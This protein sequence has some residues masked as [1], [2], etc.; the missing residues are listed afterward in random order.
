MS[1][2][3]ST[4]SALQTSKTAILEILQELEEE[5]SEQSAIL[6]GPDDDDDYYEDEEEDAKAEDAKAEEAKA[7]EAKAEEAEADGAS[8]AEIPSSK[9]CRV[10]PKPR[11][12]VDPSTLDITDT[13]VRTC[14]RAH[15]F[16]LKIATGESMLVNAKMTSA[17]LMTGILMSAV[18]TPFAALYLD[19]DPTKRTYGNLRDTV[20]LSIET[21]IASRFEMAAL[22]LHKRLAEDVCYRYEK[23]TKGPLQKLFNGRVGRLVNL[24]ME[25][26]TAQLQTNRQ[27][28]KA[29]AMTFAEARVFSVIMPQVQTAGGA[30]SWFSSRLEVPRIEV[31]SKM[32]P[33]DILP[34]PGVSKVGGTEPSPFASPYGPSGTNRHIVMRNVYEEDYDDK[35]EVRLAVLDAVKYEMTMWALD[36][37]IVGLNM[38]T[39]STKQSKAYV[40]NVMRGPEASL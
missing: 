23:S 28:W 5:I 38:D 19:L 32:L 34:K 17:P 39:Q 27:S 40:V 15:R 10:A 8:C 12:A 22:P 24:A 31:V 18:T 3:V 14:L 26:I 30:Q 25:K 7:E 35:D 37:E 33:V 36:K 2:S 13:D 9:R 20:R 1:L 11:M 29:F 6:F 16:A 4:E 21:L